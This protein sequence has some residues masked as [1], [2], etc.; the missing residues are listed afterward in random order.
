MSVIYVN[1]ATKLEKSSQ[2]TN[3]YALIFRALQQALWL[4]K[5]TTKYDTSP[6]TLRTRAAT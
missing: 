1:Y 6:P 3:E 5:Y 2:T 4:N